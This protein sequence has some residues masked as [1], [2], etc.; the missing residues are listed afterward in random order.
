MTNKLTYVLKNSFTY[1]SKGEPKLNAKEILVFAPSLS[2]R[3]QTSA[4]KKLFQDAKKQGFEIAKNLDTSPKK[5]PTPEEQEKAELAA[6]EARSKLTPEQIKKNTD[7]FIK[8]IVGLC[9]QERLTELM[10]TLLTKVREDYTSMV[11]GVEALTPYILEKMS[12]EDFDTLVLEYI[13]NFM[14]SSLTE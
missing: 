9:D 6:A 14:S 13:V 11:D 8:A 2:Q 5:V 4:L 10:I 3:V 1:S 12:L 7:D